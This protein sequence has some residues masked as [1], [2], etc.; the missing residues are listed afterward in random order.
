MIEGIEKKQYYLNHSPINFYFSQNSRDFMVKEIPLYEFSQ[1]GE[2]LIL[3]VRK[4]NLTTFE[5]INFISSILGIKSSEVGY[6]GLKD[7]SAITTQYI[8]INKLFAKELESKISL[9]EAKNIK[10]LSSTYHNNKI[11]IGHLKGNEFFI[12]LKK[13]TPAMF[14]KL[15]LILKTIQENGLPNYFGYQ[16]FGKDGDNYL[17]GKKIAHKLKKLKNRKIND[18]LISSYQ[19]YL[20]NNWLNFRIKLNKIFESFSPKEIQQ[21]L[22]LEDIFLEINEIIKIKAQKH[23]FKLF[24]GDIAHHYPYGKAFVI[25]L[26]KDTE[27]FL[28]KEITPTGIL[29]GKKTLQA[30]DLSKNIEKKFE[31]DLID[32]NG[33]R[34]FA[35]I[36]VENLRYRYVE[37]NGWLELDFFLPK[38]SYATSLIEELA[39]QKIKVD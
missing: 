21:A 18:F 26:E 36:W 15:D 28:A 22:E 33:A 29:S 19:S 16:R 12:R 1:S 13:V 32:V 6:S 31:D 38:G 2:H 17:E 23:F 3:N 10:I 27:R 11:K 20:F 5:M 24:M 14:L 34:R 9:L 35:W 7:K 8:S 25:D 37:E 30:N 39:H 4:K